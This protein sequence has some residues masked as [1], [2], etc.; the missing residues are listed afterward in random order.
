[1]FNIGFP[2]LLIIL[3]VALLVVGPS[4]LPELARSIGKAFG[5]FKRMADDVRDT[6]DQEVAVEENKEEKKDIPPQ[7]EESKSHEPPKS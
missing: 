5:Q 1:M 3:A 4:K 2:E 7:G 6:I